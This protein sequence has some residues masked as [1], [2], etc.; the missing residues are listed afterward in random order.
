[1]LN[2]DAIGRGNSGI[3]NDPGHANF[4]D[5][6]GGRSSLEYLK[7]LPFVDPKSVGMMGHSLGAEMAYK[8][9][10]H[11]PDVRGLVIT[12]FAYTMEADHRQP[13]NM[14]MV[15]GKYD[16]FRQRMTGVRDINAEWM[17]SRTDPQ[18]HS[19]GKP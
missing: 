3:P 6:Y 14:L 12:G 19:C 5:T 8:V 17:S 2:I 10:L 18:G 1:M 4:D 13:A 9:A 15:I 7:S 16:E 11:D